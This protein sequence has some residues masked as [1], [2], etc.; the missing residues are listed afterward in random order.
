[1][2]AVDLR[3]AGIGV[4]RC[5]VFFAYIDLCFL[6]PM[7]LSHCHWWDIMSQEGCAVISVSRCGGT[8]LSS[9][10]FF[11]CWMGLVCF[12]YIL[13]PRSSLRCPRR[14][15]PSSF[16]TNKITAS[17]HD[18]PQP[19]SQSNPRHSVMAIYDNKFIG[20]GNGSCSVPR[21]DRSGTGM[22]TY[23]IKVLSGCEYRP[24]SHSFRSYVSSGVFHAISRL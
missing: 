13:S 5:F 18:N 14:V 3:V 9:L 23:I 24:R 20:T 6:S 1:M 16:F 21:H 8:P 19:V 7:V 15:A 10:L 12:A 22:S 4:G 2:G 17:S 11:P